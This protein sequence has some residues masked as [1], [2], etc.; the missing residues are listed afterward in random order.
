MSNKFQFEFVPFQIGEIESFS[1]EE[2]ENQIAGFRRAHKEAARAGGY[3][4]TLYEEE[5]AYLQHEQ[6]LREQYAEGDGN[7]HLGIAGYRSIFR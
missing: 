5:I 3:D 7:R 4:L 6:L 1:D 2:I